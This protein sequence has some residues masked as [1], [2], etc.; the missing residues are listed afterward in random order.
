MRASERR[1]LTVAAALLLSGSVAAWP[2][3]DKPKEEQ[4]QTEPAA[5]KPKEPA[6]A[7]GSA[8]SDGFVIQ[9]ENGEYKLI[10]GMV[11]QA[12]GRFSLDDPK[13]IINTFTIRKIRP[14]FTGRMTRWFAFKVM[15]DF[16]NGTAVVQDAYFDIRFS[17]AF[18]LRT[19]KDKTPVGYELLEGDAFLLF[20]ERALASS[21]VP[22]RDIGIQAQGDIAGGKLLYSAGVFNGVPDGT[23]STTELDTNNA[24]D[25]AG[26]FL[27]QPFKSAQ[28]PAGALNGLGFHVGG[29]VGRQF[30]AL[31]S[32][33]TSVGQTYFSYSTAAAAAG[34]RKRVSPAVFYYYKSF[35]AFAEYMR[36]AQPVAKGGVQTRVTNQA[37]EVTA[38]FLVTG[39]A[40][41]Y[42]G[43][44][45]KHNFDPTNGH[46]GGLQLLGRYTTL[47]V[48]PAAF[49][50]GLAAANASRQARSF[51][52]AANWYPT[53]YIKYYVTFERTVFDGNAAGPRP[54]ENVILVR[55][56][57]GF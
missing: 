18:R 9:F 48:D 31:P 49:T 1:V 27:V 11:A 53:A 15:P 35:G 55:A 38:S 22:N 36:S 29:S 33:K 13:P 4:T 3:D 30:G 39:E 43:V 28:A 44:R 7:A 26:R 17:P 47:K 51:T 54:A 40:A 20:P 56:Q 10:L 5:D 6:T 16:G 2:A 46:W 37:W 34:V 23:S 21:L 45:P 12:D 41:S 52:I 42:S 14:T 24:K 32:F 57:L 19:G 8:A 50:A 25:V